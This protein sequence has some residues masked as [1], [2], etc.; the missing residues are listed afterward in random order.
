MFRVFVLTTVLVLLGVTT[1]PPL[2]IVDAD[3]SSRTTVF[4]LVVLVRVSIPAF[5][6]LLDVRTF[7]LKFEAPLTGTFVFLFIVPPAVD[8]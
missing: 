8:C 2:K 5:L 7:E 4:V 3:L 1:V 6:M